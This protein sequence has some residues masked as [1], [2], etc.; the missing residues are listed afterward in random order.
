[1]SIIWLNDNLIETEKL[2]S[3]N[4]LNSPC[5]CTFIIITN[6]ISVLLA[7][8]YIYF[9]KLNKKLHNSQSKI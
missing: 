2:D 8:A 9:Y 4:S 5:D 3:E 6:A 1:M 7:A